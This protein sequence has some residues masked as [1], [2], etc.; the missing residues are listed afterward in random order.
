MSTSPARMRRTT[1][2][3]RWNHTS[4]PGSCAA[5]TTKEVR[6]HEPPGAHQ[7][8]CHERACSC[9]PAPLSLTNH[10]TT[11]TLAPSNTPIIQ[12]GGAVQ[13]VWLLLYCFSSA[14]QRAVAGFRTTTSSP[15][16]LEDGIH[17][18]GPP[19]GGNTGAQRTHAPSADLC[20][21]AHMRESTRGGGTFSSTLTLL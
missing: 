20:R 9:T 8:R 21:L 3:A 18:W 10:R 12:R 4:T 15:P 11:R 6:D 7:R 2:E 14:L 16:A 17:W 1:S 13:I 5:P 19:Q